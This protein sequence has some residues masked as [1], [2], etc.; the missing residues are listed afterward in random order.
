MMF[1]SVKRVS[2]RTW[3][4]PAAARGL[5]PNSTR[6]QPA[7]AGSAGEGA[8]TPGKTCTEI[9]GFS[10]HPHKISIAP[11]SNCLQTI[12][13]PPFIYPVLPQPRAAASAADKDR[14]A[15]S[16]SAWDSAQPSSTSASSARV[17]ARRM[18]SRSSEVRGSPLK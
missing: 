14:S 13:L 10:A 3:Y 15:S 16:S 12:F 17:S 9:A 11:H 2:P 5:P 6:S 7:G 1:H 8:S 4:T 18:R